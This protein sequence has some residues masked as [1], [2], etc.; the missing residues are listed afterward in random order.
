M[1][2][3]TAALAGLCALP[4]AAQEPIELT[5][6][7]TV[8]FQGPEA[9]GAVY[10]FADAAF[11]ITLNWAD[12]GEWV[13][14]VTVMIERGAAPTFAFDIPAGLSGFG[15]IGVYEMGDAAG[16]VL[17]VGAYTGGAHCCEQIYLVDLGQNDTTPIDAGMYDGGVIYPVDADG[18]GKYEIVVPDPRF[19]YTF[20]CYACGAPPDAVFT[21]EGGNFVEIS[22]RP[23]FRD[24]FVENFNY[25][26]ENCGAGEEWSAG[27]CAGLLGAAARLGIYEGTLAILRPGLAAKGGKLTMTWD[28][29]SFCANDDCSEQ[30]VIKDFAEAVD[31]ALREWGYLPAN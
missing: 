30:T 14:S 21:L 6:N 2:L 1:R 9:E 4:A 31:Y 13:E 23:Q 22:D 12:G 27:V 18:D 10:S 17:I 24:L 7:E 28:E 20:D 15:Q 11:Q 26:S 3:I 25:M 8:E 19:H 5:L 29:F 16:P